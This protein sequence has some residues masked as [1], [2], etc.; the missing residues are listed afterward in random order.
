MTDAAVSPPE[1]AAPDISVV[2]PVHNES[3]AAVPLAREI[4]AAFAGR[5]YEMIFVDDASTD[6][7]LA[8]LKSVWAELGKRGV[9]DKVRVDFVSVDP[10]RDTADT[11]AKYVGFF[12]PDFVAATGAAPSQG[13]CSCRKSRGMTAPPSRLSP[14]LSALAMRSSAT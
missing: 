7:T 4:A 1:T 14:R 9:Q 5:S 11:L 8:E 13:P 2:V 3:G 12:S 10:E 6:T